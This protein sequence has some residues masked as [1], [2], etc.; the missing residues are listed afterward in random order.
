MS[1]LVRRNT[2]MQ[3]AVLL[4]VSIGA[5]NTALAVEPVHATTGVVQKVDTAAKTI[6]VKTAD[7]TVKVF[8]YTERT[9]V[10]GVEDVGKGTKK[11]SVD[12]YHGTLEG[13]H[14]VVHYTEKG[15]ED[16]AVGVKDVGKG[17]VKVSDG[18]VD[19]VDKSAHTLTVKTKDGSKETYALSKDATIDTSH[20]VV[21]SAKW[22]YKE[23]DKVTVHYTEEAGKKVAYFVHHL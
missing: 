9:T 5:W 16:T 11:G 17:T 8:K 21:D 6:A 15:G 2:L 14:A 20:G 3:I 10:E 18:T 23:G 13:S 7:G 4:A 22:T 19:H 12:T 1:L